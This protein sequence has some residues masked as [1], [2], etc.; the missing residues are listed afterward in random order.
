M[1]RKRK[2]RKVKPWEKIHD[3]LAEILQ[4]LRFKKTNREYAKV[5]YFGTGK[6]L[7]K[8]CIKILNIL[9]TMDKE[10]EYGLSAEDRWT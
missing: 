9:T 4:A 5:V 6:E 10:L 7:R 3:E 1:A 2:P 8:R